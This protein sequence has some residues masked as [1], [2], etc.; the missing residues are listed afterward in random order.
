MNHSVERAKNS[1][2]CMMR[3]M[4]GTMCLVMPGKQRDRTF[5]SL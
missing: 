4:C 1:A 5:L 2:M 3:L